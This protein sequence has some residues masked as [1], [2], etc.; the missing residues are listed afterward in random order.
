MKVSVM[1][2]GLVVNLFAGVA[3]GAGSARVREST[4]NIHTFYVLWDSPL[5]K[6]FCVGMNEESEH[7]A[8]VWTAAPF[9]TFRI[10]YTDSL[11]APE[12][13]PLGEGTATTDSF[14]LTDTNAWP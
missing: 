7:P 4:V 11:E 3:W 10:E 13:K 5:S 9:D 6:T 1:R 2:L 8:P 12:W 14:S